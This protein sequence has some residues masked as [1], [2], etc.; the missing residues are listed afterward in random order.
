MKGYMESVDVSFLH[1]SNITLLTKCPV[2]P[3]AEEQ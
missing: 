2:S 1:K 3:N